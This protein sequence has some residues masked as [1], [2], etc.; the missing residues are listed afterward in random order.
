MNDGL[1]ILRELLSGRPVTFV[2]DIFEV[3]DGVDGRLRAP[4]GGSMSPRRGM[5]AGRPGEIVEVTMTRHFMLPKVT[6]IT[7]ESA[8]PAGPARPAGGR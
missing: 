2:G 7:P 4:T 3:A 8:T 1:Q 5:C 6:E